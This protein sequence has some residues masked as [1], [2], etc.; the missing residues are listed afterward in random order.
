MCGIFGAVLN[1]PI[2]QNRLRHLIRHAEQRG[3]DSSGLALYSQHG[4][5]E[6]FKADEPISR[7][8][9]RVKSTK[10]T[11]IV[12]HSRLITNGMNDN[13]PVHNE[14]VLVFHNGIVID[15]EEVWSSIG[16][17]PELEIDTEIIAELAR[18]HIKS[19]GTLDGL[20]E[21]I[22]AKCKGSIS[23]AVLAPE[24]GEIA[25][26]SNTGSMFL[27][28]AEDG[29]YFS[30]EEHPL[31]TL[32]LG[33][34]SQV[35]SL[36]LLDSPRAQ[37]IESTEY[38]NSRSTLVPKFT[39]NR[40][41]FNQ[42]ENNDPSMRRCS[43]CI[44]PETMPFIQFDEQGVCN[45]CQ[46]YKPKNV[47]KPLD[48]LRQLLE[49]YRRSRGPEAI[50]PFSGGRD[51]SFALHLVSRELGLRTVAYTY[52]WGMVT[53][54]GRRNI[55]RMCAQLGI[56]NIVVAADIAKKRRNIRLNL[57]AWLKQPHLGMLSLLTAG[58]KHFF[59]YVDRVRL[60]TGTSLNIWGINPL[61]TTHFKAGF[62]GVAPDFVSNRVYH[63]GLS[64]QL[65]YQGL[66]FNVMLRNPSFINRSIPDTLSGEF[67]RSIAPKH[68]YI[69]LFDYWRWDEEEIN[70]TL[71]E[72]YDWELASDTTTTWRIGDGTAAFYNYVYKTVAGFSEHDTFR[73]NQIR[74]GDISREKALEL[75]KIENQPRYE[76][77]R[78][79]LD[80]VGINFSEAIKRV[81][82]M[83][84]LYH[85]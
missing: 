63:S 25:L 53:D 10:S 57:E 51:S 28:V 44:L 36:V 71:I 66:R 52:D 48:N 8:N 18:L 74:E 11:C 9:A 64:A 73:S 68:D 59:K 83:P 33:P 47:P 46:N 24:I 12:G 49:T 34:V 76:N 19:S 69:H 40:Q 32:G 84:K 30:S 81:N 79:Y 16:K 21:V 62:L 75:V 3:K 45:F 58:D 27:L 7:L 29:Y 60:Q 5:V 54:L 70:Q 1:H 41:E 85:D 39:F 50:M 31:L 2:P 80:A 77:I 65:R 17:Q 15:P 20:D 42:L 6:V 37:V 82:Q 43:R 26:F 35:M 38:K 78:W 67:Y 56:E 4:T 55:S 14:D 22:F 61:E 13:Q 23:C 72:E